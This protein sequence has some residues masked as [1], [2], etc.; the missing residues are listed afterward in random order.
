MLKILTRKLTI[1]KIAWNFKMYDYVQKDV[2]HEF[3][4][5]REAWNKLGQLSKEDAMTEYIG[6]LSNIDVDWEE[7]VLIY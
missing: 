7:K 3:S 2:E 4:A 5:F 1:Y 6:E